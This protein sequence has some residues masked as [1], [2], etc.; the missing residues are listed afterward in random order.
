MDLTQDVRPDLSSIEANSSKNKELGLIPAWSYSS[1]KTFETC[2]YRV[3]LAKV[4]N[5]EEE[6]LIKNTTESNSFYNQTN[7][8][9]RDNLYNTYDYFSTL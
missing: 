4:K 8:I 7:I 5:V 3:Y 2:P 1:L 6:N 9:Q